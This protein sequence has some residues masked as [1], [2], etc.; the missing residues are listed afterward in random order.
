M[1]CSSDNHITSMDHVLSCLRILSNMIHLWV[2]FLSGDVINLHAMTKG[3]N[4]VDELLLSEKH[5]VMKLY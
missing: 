5:K 4:K 3:N 1:N 2:D